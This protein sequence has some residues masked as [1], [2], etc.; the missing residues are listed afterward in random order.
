MMRAYTFYVRQGNAA[1]FSGGSNAYRVDQERS[2]PVWSRRS[3]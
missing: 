1:R 3:L 2:D